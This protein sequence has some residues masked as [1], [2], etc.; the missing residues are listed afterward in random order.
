MDKR[1]RKQIIIALI[2]FS[3]FSLIGGGFF[4]TYRSAPSC[5]DNKR[6]QGEEDIDCG[7]SCILCKLKYNP[8]LSLADDPVLLINQNDKVDILFKIANSNLDWGAQ[9]FSYKVILI[10]ENQEKQEFVKSGFIFPH[11]IRYFIVPNIAVAFKPL[12]ADIEILKETI[13]WNKP[14]TGID[15]NLGDPFIV[16]C[17]L[18]TSDAADDLLCV[19]LGG[20]RIIKKKKNIK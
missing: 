17:L 19:D 2:F 6:N 5:F 14:L 3:I 4:L 9:G 1:L 13:V 11:E 10:G 18:Y 7:G 12:K 16:T 20:R 8:P 15:L